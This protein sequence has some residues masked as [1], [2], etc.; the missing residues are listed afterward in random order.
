MQEGQAFN[1]GARIAGGPDS[2]SIGVPQAQEE[3]STAETL[4][5]LRQPDRRAIGATRCFLYVGH[6]A[7]NGRA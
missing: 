4:L 3:F 6:G 7:V 2:L 5:R 1:R